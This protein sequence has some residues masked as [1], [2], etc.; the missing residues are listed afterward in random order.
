MGNG[1]LA[2]RA[3]GEVNASG[4]VGC[5]KGKDEASGGCAATTVGAEGEQDAGTVLDATGT[6][7]YAGIG[8]CDGAYSGL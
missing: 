1:S 3:V 8:Q 2:G 6:R 5:K 7:L 4:Q